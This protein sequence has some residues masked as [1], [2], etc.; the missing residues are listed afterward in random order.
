VATRPRSLNRDRVHVVVPNDID[1]PARPSGGNVYDRRICRGLTAAGWNVHEHA[2]PG[3]WPAAGARERSELARV[4]VAL[5][6]DALVL[7]DGLIASAGPDVLT[8]QSRRLRLV[9]LMHMPLGDDGAD[10]RDAEGEA[11]GA[12]AAVI[13]TSQWCR[14]RLMDLYP[15]T[16]DRIHVAAPG[17][18]AGAVAPGSDGGSRLLSVAAVTRTK[19]HDVLVTALADVADLD[20]SCR[21]VGAVDREPDFADRLARRTRALGIADRIAFVGPRTGRDLAASYAAADLF[22]LASRA[23][24][25]GMVVTE[26]LARGIPVLAT[27]TKGLPEALGTAPDGD[28]PGILAPPGI[29]VPPDDPAALSAALRR[30]L[31]D[32]TL[33]D[34]LRRRA[35]ARRAALTG[36]ATTSALVADALRTAGANLET[37]R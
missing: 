15:L 3:G 29:L 23:E 5:P 33:R 37:V 2:V 30:W 31:R 10:R 9:V 19:G 17:V 27:A 18:D 35:R 14:R 6:D 20:W 28:A 32:K 24:T 36:W 4:L 7:I 12:A 1:D 21:C 22:V 25:Y 8:P 26:A 11:L 13:T 34:R 16:P